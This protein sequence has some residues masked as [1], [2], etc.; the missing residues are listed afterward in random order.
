MRWLRPSRGRRRCRTA[1]VPVLPPAR[2]PRRGRWARPSRG[3]G[4]AA[5]ALPRPRRARRSGRI[6]AWTPG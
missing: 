4:R 6:R 5:R 3:R 1:L 2:R